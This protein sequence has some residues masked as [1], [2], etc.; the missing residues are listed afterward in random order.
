MR[1]GFLPGGQA[2]Q[3][4]GHNPA[5]PGDLIEPGVAARRERAESFSQRP[6]VGRREDTSRPPRNSVKSINGS[7]PDS[8]GELVR[9]LWDD[10][11]RSRDR[12][13]MWRRSPLNQMELADA[14]DYFALPGMPDVKDL[15]LPHFHER[16]PLIGLNYTPS[17][18]AYLHHF[19]GGWTDP[20]RF[21]RGHVWNQDGECLANPLPKFFNANEPGGRWVD[22]SPY[23]ITVKL[24]GHMIIGFDYDGKYI[25]K[26]RGSFDHESAQIAKGYINTGTYDLPG[27]V[28]WELIHTGTRVKIDYPAH[29]QGLHLIAY[30]SADGTDVPLGNLPPIARKINTRYIPN[31]TNLDRSRLEQIPLEPHG[32]AS[33]IPCE[34]YVVRFHDEANTRIKYK[35]GQALQPS[36]GLAGGEDRIVPRYSAGLHSGRPLEMDSGHRQSTKPH[37]DQSGQSSEDRSDPEV[38]DW[39]D[40]ER[41]G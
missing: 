27:T 26:T 24:D 5:G 35:Y 37:G 18:G 21:C 38:Y 11:V 41:S 13:H 8:L 12:W 29:M 36:S 31:A 30:R 22:G 34:G 2:R 9:T 32:I 7:V 3:P 16:L 6:E 33:G 17:A 10:G 40:Y 19:P 25:L 14:L 4:V 28:V 20:L 15:I 39:L 1:R 23:D